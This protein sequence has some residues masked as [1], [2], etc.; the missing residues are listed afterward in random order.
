[1]KEMMTMPESYKYE[2]K[3]KFTSEPRDGSDLIDLITE[4][5]KANSRLNEAR[6][7]AL[8]LME[9]AILSKTA[10]QKSREQLALSLEAAKMGS[11]EWTSET[12]R[13]QLSEASIEVLGLTGDKPFLTSE[14]GYKLVHPDDLEKRKATFEKSGKLGE[15]YYN[16][17]RIIRPLDQKIAWIAEKGK[18]VRDDKTGITV[19]RGVHWDMTEKK[20]AEEAL[21]RSREELRQFN[22]TLEQQIQARTKELQKQNNI[23]KQAEELAQAGSWEYNVVTKE[24]IWS[25]GMYELFGLKKGSVITPAVYTDVA[26]EKDRAKAQKIVDAIRNDYRPFEETISISSDGNARI[27]KVKGAPLKN[28]K[29]EIEKVLGVDM[30]IT[31]VQE[32]H[33]RVMDLNKTLLTL[34]RESDSLNAELKTFASIAANNYG[35]TLRQLY[36][37]IELIVTHDARNLSNSGRANLRRA[38]SGIQKLKLVTDDLVF[39]SRLQEMG[40]KEE[41]IDL[42][43]LLGNLA[44]EFLSQPNAPG[45]KINCDHF[46]PINGYPELLSLLFHHLLD[47]AIKFRKADTDHVVHIACAEID[48]SEISGETAEKDKRYLAVSFIDNGIGFPPEESAK[49]F[50]MFYRVHEKGK[51]RGSGVG[52]SISKK[53]MEIHGGFITAESEEDKGASFYCYFPAE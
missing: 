33:Q 1:M 20:D 26:V 50:E 41:A 24:F 25:D 21:L 39:F 14:E 5:Q 34:N 19:I 16:E 29:A 12:R 30:D 35:E 9:D 48:D 6:R 46:P 28:E 44:T 52:L 8:N 45:V 17:F 38:Q 23:L 37:N 15:D 10:L 27:I 7:A 11:F 4:L 13:I 49:I 51:Y 32:S 18:A 53:I 31:E 3:Q 36:L 2:T 22:A 43:A 40:E 42:N 47:N